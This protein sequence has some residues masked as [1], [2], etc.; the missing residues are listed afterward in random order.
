MANAGCGLCAGA[1]RTSSRRLAKRFR[2]QM[3]SQHQQMRHAINDVELA[4]NGLE[5]DSVVR[6]FKT[7]DDYVMVKLPLNAVRQLDRCHPALNRIINGPVFERPSG[8]PQIY[9]TRAR[10]SEWPKR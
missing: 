3:K 10:T 6:L 9:P 7:A 8:P 1:F 4:L 5:I 2:T